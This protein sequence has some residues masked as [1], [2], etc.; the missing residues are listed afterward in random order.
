MF[1]MKKSKNNV[2]SVLIFL[3][4]SIFCMGAVAFADAGGS[5]GSTGTITIEV[6]GSYNETTNTIGQ[7]ILYT[8]T[9]LQDAENKVS[10]DINQLKITGGSVTTDD[11]K[12]L[13]N[14]D[15]LENFQIDST[16]TNVEICLI[17]MITMII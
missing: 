11:W 3:M 4:L 1:H 16:V 17:Y 7:G 14:I 15:T 8:G 5:T 2:I 6:N 13:I 12:Y 10:S 9:S